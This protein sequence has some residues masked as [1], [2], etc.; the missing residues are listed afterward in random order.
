MREDLTG[1]GLLLR[2]GLRRDRLRLPIWTVAIAA[3][4]P[5][6]F[7]SLADTAGEDPQGAVDDL[8][9]AQTM[10]AIFAGPVYGLDAVTLQKYFLM[11]NQEF[12]IAA[13]LMS[14][15]LVVRHTRGEE[16]SG[17]A[18]LVRSAV[19]GRHAPLT[20][21]LL[22]GVITNAVLAAL[23]FVGALGIGFGASDAALYGVS[24]AAT[25]L[26]FAAV[27]A[28]A[29]Q[30]VESGRAAGGI[31]GVVL[32]AASI[33]RGAA[34]AQ[35][36]DSVALW[37]SPMAWANLTKPITDPTWWPVLLTMGSG[38]V[39]AAVGY[40]LSVRRDVG[41]GFFAPRRGRVGASRWLSSP[42]AL[43][44]RMQ[45]RTIL[46]WALAMGLLGMVWGSLV[47]TGEAIEGSEAM[48]GTE[49]ERGYLSLLGVTQ[50][51]LVGVFALTSMARVRSE[52]VDGRLDSALGTAT[53][54][55]SWL[56]SWTLVTV[57]GTG[58][59]LLVS[60]LGL[61]LAAFGATGHAALLSASVGGVVGRFPE[62]LALIGISALL[63]GIGPRWQGLTW[64]VF[65]YGVVI[66]FFGQSL[67]DAV[68]QLSI[69]QHIPRMPAEEFSV[70]PLVYLSV[71][72]VALVGAALFAFRHR[73]L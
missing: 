22:V 52:E 13:A 24:I 35:G 57:L 70:V 33:G 5:F 8:A 14:I 2:L 41:L 58:L 23:L 37:F 40:A 15:L 51:L 44:L 26:F 48:F 67:P 49:L 31:A 16:Q 71:G 36:E 59:L 12:L 69:F 1:T 68:Q 43:A 45:R 50:T 29:V 61:G 20:A 66:R 42:F 34:A 73:D 19:I 39:F 63:Y 25:G 54:R 7:S 47:G 18:E 32:A 4:V 27:T 6:F 3:F 21:A 28:V 9:Q 11:Y 17:R 72:G 55:F 64:V 38:A 53:G 62:L 30:V 65:G 56:G 10:L 60:G 46:W